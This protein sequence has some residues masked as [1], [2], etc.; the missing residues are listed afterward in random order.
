MYDFIYFYESGGYMY[1][2]LVKR[3]M[4][5]EP[6]KS[7]VYRKIEWKMWGDDPLRGY[8]DEEDVI[9]REKKDKWDII[10]NESY[11]VDGKVKKKQQHICTVTYWDIVDSWYSESIWDRTEKKIENPEKY[12]EVLNLIY[13]K[14]QPVVDQVMKEYEA[15]EEY[16]YKTINNRLKKE[17]QQEVDAEK[18][19]QSKKA[20]HDSLLGQG[21]YDA[22]YNKDG[23]YN[24][25]KAHEWDKTHKKH[26]QSNNSNYSDYDFNSFFKTSGATLNFKDNEKSIAEEL[27]KAG[28]RALVKKY[29]PDT[30]G[31]NE[32]FQSLSN[33]KDK[34]INAVK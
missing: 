14:F 19:Y 18:Q 13:E 23:T 12:E 3:K 33:L 11:R 32:Q 4:I 5:K 16:N 25:K 29:H 24:F 15:S 9:K 20:E 2:T 26:E 8:W 22:H 17:K 34:L 10:L 21:Y 28:Y 6:Y 27:I 30:G 1:C 31:T 7:C